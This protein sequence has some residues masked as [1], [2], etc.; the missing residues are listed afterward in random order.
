MSQLLII[1]GPSGVGKNT[2]TDAIIREYPYLKYFRKITTRD[3]RPDDRDTEARF[4]TGG[5]YEGLRLQHRI[6]LPYEIRSNNTNSFAFCHSEFAV[7]ILYFTTILHI[8]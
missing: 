1:C 4:V 5:E 8:K 7:P 2:L 6:A 3:K